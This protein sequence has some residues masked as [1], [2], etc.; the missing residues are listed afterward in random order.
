MNTPTIRSPIA[1]ASSAV[2]TIFGSSSAISR[3]RQRAAPTRL[4]VVSGD[5]TTEF[6]LKEAAPQ[7]HSGAARRAEPGTHEHGRPE[8][9]H[10]VS[11]L[12]YEGGV[13]GFRARGFAAPRNDR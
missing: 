4:T 3:A 5:A 8:S 1:N 11:A 6:Q 12:F 2:S 10:A 13:H 9:S 7:R